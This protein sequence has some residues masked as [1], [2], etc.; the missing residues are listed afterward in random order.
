VE[1]KIHC[2]LL[3]AVLGQFERLVDLSHQRRLV[4]MARLLRPNSRWLS[5]KQRCQEQDCAQLNA[6]ASISH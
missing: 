2:P 1:D 5:N 4:G 6:T 3:V